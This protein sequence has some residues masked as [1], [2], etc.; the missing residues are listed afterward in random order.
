MIP[1]YALFRELI[2]NRDGTVD[3]TYVW[4]GRSPSRRRWSG[5]ISSQGKLSLRDEARFVDYRLVSANVL[6]GEFN[7]STGSFKRK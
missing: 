1:H 6:A 2:S 5:T 3:A 7:T 4:G